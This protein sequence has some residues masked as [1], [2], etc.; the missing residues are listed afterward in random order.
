MASKRRPKTE[1]PVEPPKPAPRAG[2]S[3]AIARIAEV[4]AYYRPLGFF[5]REP[6][7]SSERLAEDL[8]DRP[9]EWQ[10]PLREWKP[11]A[12]DPAAFADL[13]VLGHDP[14]RVFRLESWEILLATE[15]RD[16][17]YAHC[18]TYADVVA[19]LARIS[20]HR[21]RLSSG[22]EKGGAMTIEVDGEPKRIKFRRDGKALSLDFLEALDAAIEPTGHGFAFVS[23]RFCQGYI[24][25]L[26]HEE[27]DRLARERRWA[28]FTLAS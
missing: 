14:H 21:F 1:A 15:A 26:S 11:D 6:E 12:D 27:R 22:K 17:G 23:N 8:A 28:Y 5:A 18:P 24:V 3:A 25:L 4:I 13:S 20:A 7:T 10:G 16:N 19:R 2:A 9:D